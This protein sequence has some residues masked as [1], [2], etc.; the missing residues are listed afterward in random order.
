MKKK[1]ENYDL[2]TL[3]EISEK[4]YEKNRNI[5]IHYKQEIKNLE[6]FKNRTRVQ[7]L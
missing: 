1:Q 7:R 3:G 6:R 2:N 4:F 5:L